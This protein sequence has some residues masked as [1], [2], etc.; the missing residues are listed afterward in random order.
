[1]DESGRR[2]ACVFQSISM[3]NSDGDVAL[4]DGRHLDLEIDLIADRGGHRFDF[5]R[6][7]VRGRKSRPSL[8]AL[9][10]DR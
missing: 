2:P 9:R 7:D 4:A 10:L 8:Q 3:E 6:G 1:M 5:F